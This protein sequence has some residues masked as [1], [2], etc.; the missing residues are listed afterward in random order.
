M[1]KNRNNVKFINNNSNG[2]KLNI[3][4]TLSFSIDFEHSNFDLLQ[5]SGAW[6]REKN[7]YKRAL[8]LGIQSIDSK[9]G[10]SK[11]CR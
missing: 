9:K 6:C 1:E 4:K 3:Q 11:K 8:V 7:I 5:L 2:E 10:I